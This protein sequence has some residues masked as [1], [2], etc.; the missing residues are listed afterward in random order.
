MRIRLTRT[1]AAV[2]IA[3][4]LA[5][6][7]AACGGDSNDAASTTSGGADDAAVAEFCSELDRLEVPIQELA[8][9]DPATTTSEDLATLNSRLGGNA[10]NLGLAAQGAQISTE[11]L[12][13]ELAALQKAITAISDPPTDAEVTAI[14]DSAKAVDT[15]I[16]TLQDDH[17][18]DDGTSTG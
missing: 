6:G 10:N 8:E 7:A 18:S 4:A 17:C 2:A 14:E 5:L 12:G 1:F 16:V 9:I 15:E 11:A 3:G 13:T